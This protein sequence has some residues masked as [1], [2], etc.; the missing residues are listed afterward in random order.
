A[1]GD[2]LGRGAPARGRARRGPRRIRLRREPDRDPAQA[3]TRSVIVV[4]CFNEAG[5]LDEG[6]FA[7]AARGPGAPRVLFVDH[8][9]RRGT[10]AILARLATADPA[11]C[12]R[13]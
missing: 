3:M 9:S 1:R 12:Q 4:P 5:R 8:G 7:R 10:V 2:P 6:A 13:L 11:P